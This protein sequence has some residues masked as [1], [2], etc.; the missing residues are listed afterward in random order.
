MQRNTGLRSIFVIFWVVGSIF[1]VL[2]GALDGNFVR[3]MIYIAIGW[4]IIFSYLTW[5][6]S[7]DATEFEDDD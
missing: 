1:W 2:L 4:V 3:S 6:A 7:K 5:R